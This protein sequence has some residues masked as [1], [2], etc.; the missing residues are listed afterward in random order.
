MNARQGKTFED[1]INVVLEIRDD[2]RARGDWNTSDS[3][4]DHLRKIGIGLEDTSSG[5]RWYMASS[6]P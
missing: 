1:L 4:R 2:A 6:K 5:V 3:I